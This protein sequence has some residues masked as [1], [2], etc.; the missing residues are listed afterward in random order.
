MVRSSKFESLDICSIAMCATLLLY[1]TAAALPAI[2]N[3]Q[4]G[5][6]A[7]GAGVFGGGGQGSTVVVGGTYSYVPAPGGMQSGAG[8]G[9][10]SGGGSSPS[11]PPVRSVPT[12]NPDVVGQQNALTGGDSTWLI[13]QPDGTTMQCGGGRC[14][15]LPDAGIPPTPITLAEVMNVVSSAV[16]ALQIEPIDVGITPEPAYL[17]RTGLVGMNSWLWVSNPREATTG[18]ITRTV[19]SG[20]VTVS[21]NAV[22]TGLL[23][24][25]GDG[26][27]TIPPVC[28]IAA[29]AYTDAALGLPSPLCNH[30][31]QKS[32]ML[33]PGGVFRPSVTSLWVVTWSA[34]V[35]GQVFAGTIPVTPTA[36][37]EVRIGEL[38]VLVTN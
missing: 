16:S 37:T 6:G 11:V 31:L 25:Y 28:P 10:V 5:T 35:P 12:S 29:P 13:D 22:N 14:I 18:P 23:V 21:L 17:G 33:E 8:Q 15:T 26:L 36:T 34:V 19:T 1:L 2:S 4:P 38:Q 24:N 32:S 20:V 7:G 3:A 9:A 27:P 30:F